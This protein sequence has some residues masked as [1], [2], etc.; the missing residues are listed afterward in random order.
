MA[1]IT[2]ALTS[3]T[4][5]LNGSAGTI[6]AAS[7]LAGQLTA[8]FAGTITSRGP[9][10]AALNLTGQNNL[11]GNSLTM[12]SAGNVAGSALTLAGG[13]GTINVASWT[14]G[15]IQA[16]YLGTVLSRGGFGATVNVT[17]N[18]R[19]TSLQMA[20]ITGALTSPT[21]TLNASAGTIIAASWPAGQL[22]ATYAGTIISRGPLGATLNLTGENA[23]HNSLT[24]LSATGAV[25]G[26]TL[27]L[28]GGAGTII[29][30]SWAVG[31]T[32]ARNIGTF[33]SRGDFV[34]NLRLT[35]CTA[36]GGSLTMLSITRRMENAEVRARGGIGTL[37]VGSMI[38]SKVFV[39][40]LDT[41]TGL[42]TQPTQPTDY[43]Q[44]PPIANKPSS[45]TSLTVTS[46]AGAFQNSVVA[47]PSMGTVTLR[48]V[49]T[50]NGTPFGLLVDTK[51]STLMRFRP[52]A[53]PS[54]KSPVTATLTV[55]P[56]EGDF[57][58]NVV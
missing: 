3:P 42:P 19:G 57:Q 5:T 51:I 54:I 20:S 50:A 35:G 36:L 17:G 16:S 45:I 12:L 26:A 37:L 2:G 56:A 52:G 53:A 58:I 49:Q 31:Q 6:T 13:A 41:I 55:L 11:T 43:F 27:T 23:A 18:R 25:N 38:N 30:G 44:A 10:G 21:I 33:M 47:A 14:G 15:S 39:S 28:Y 9:L 40:V 48:G 7:W 8:T 22:T 46:L 24:M 29:A 4:I 1:S 32:T 34:G